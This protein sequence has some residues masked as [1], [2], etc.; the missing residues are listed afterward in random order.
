MEA[1]YIWSRCEETLFQ[2]C[3]CGSF[4]TEEH[5]AAEPRGSQFTY[6]LGAEVCL[7]P[8]GKQLFTSLPPKIPCLFLY[9]DGSIV[10]KPR[11]PSCKFSATGGLAVLGTLY[12]TGPPRVA[13]T[14]RREE[15]DNKRSWMTRT[16]N[17]KAFGIIILSISGSRVVSACCVIYIQREK[18]EMKIR[19]VGG[20]F[21]YKWSREVLMKKEADNW[22]RS[23]TH[24]REIN[25]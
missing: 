3:S 4:G 7:N 22:N 19:E 20:E 9:E 5:L 25:W 23:R 17:N 13:R 8:F 6:R 10:T 2:G 24:T 18:S 1:T 11:K 14:V 12:N 21:V 16:D 15:D